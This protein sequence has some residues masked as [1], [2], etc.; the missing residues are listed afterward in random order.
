[1]RTC[2]DVRKHYPE[3]AAR[4]M[5]GSFYGWDLMTPQEQYAGTHADYNPPYPEVY[6]EQ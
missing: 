6:F 1:M 4:Y 3:V 2:A 5:S